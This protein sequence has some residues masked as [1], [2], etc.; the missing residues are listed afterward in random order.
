MNIENLKVGDCIEFKACTRSHFRKAIRKITKI[1]WI[2][3]RVRYHG[4][5][6]FALYSHEIIRKIGE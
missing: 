6:D 3:V 5:G 1:D 2:G 4:C